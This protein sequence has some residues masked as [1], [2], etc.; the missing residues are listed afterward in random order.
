MQAGFQGQV[1]RLSEVGEVKR[2]YDDNE[3]IHKVNAREA[4]MFN[5]VK[6]SSYGILETLNAATKVAERFKSTTL[7]DSPIEL[8]L[9]DDESIDVQ[10]RLSIITT[11]GGIG[12]FLILAILFI[13]LDWRA[14]FWVAM[15]IPFTLCFT[16]TVAS[17]LGYTIN[18]TTLAAVIIVM[19]IVV[20]DAIIV[21]ENITRLVQQG[22][23][24]SEAVIKGAGEV[25]VPIFASIITTCV[26][27]IPLLFFDGHFGAFIA[28]I[29]PIIFL[30]LGASFLESVFILPGHMGVGASSKSTTANPKG[31]WFDRV[32]KLYQKILRAVLPFRTVILLIFTALLFFSWRIASEQMKFVMFPNEETRDIVLT[33]E[34]AEGS[35]RE[36]T[37]IKLEEIEKLILPYVGKEVVGFRSERLLVVEEVVW[38]LKTHLGQLSK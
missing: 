30:M 33:G 4:V 7:K 6:N 16:M 28:F 2:G 21:A 11:N 23:S 26:A 9:L 15:G 37:A 31:H 32:E 8:V 35:T 3:P 13:F 20:D 29:P 25:L 36:E 19:G 5:I 27:F 1:V 22:I 18:G 17:F 24:R 38:L 34:T 10:N 14:G 12:F